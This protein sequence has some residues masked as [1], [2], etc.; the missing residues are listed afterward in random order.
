MSKNGVAPITNVVVLM[1]E[2]RS[3][4]NVLGTLY[5]R[6]DSFEG[7]P[8]DSKNYSSNGVA[9]RVNNNPDSTAVPPIDPGEAFADMNLQIFGNTDGTG[10]A[11]MSGFVLDYL[12]TSQQ[13][14]DIPTKPAFWYTDLP[15]TDPVTGEH[16]RAKEIMNYFTSSGDSPQMAVTGELAQAFAV[17]DSWFGSCPTQTFANRLFL[18]CASSGGFVDDYEY[19][20][21]ILKEARIPNLPSIFERLDTL[22][23]DTPSI[24]NWKVYFH[25][26]PGSVFLIDYVFQALTSFS[27]N[28]CHF[29][30][31]K[32]EIEPLLT[33]TFLDDLKNGTL[34][35]FSLIEPMYANHP[36]NS[37]PLF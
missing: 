14:P 4:D 2:N 12:A 22:R 25:D 11:S 34:P 24:E 32:P 20:E 28:V 33:P 17:T 30:G 19:I 18:T 27:G 9:H 26:V 7:L 16:A 15:R 10:E 36:D 3:F 31:N 5:P 13:Y 21:F 1:L 35:R 37:P 29:D 6:S 23:P 8:L